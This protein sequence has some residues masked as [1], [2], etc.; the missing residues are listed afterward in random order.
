M[1]TNVHSYNIHC[2]GCDI[3]FVPTAYRV[4][5]G[6]RS[7]KVVHRGRAIDN[8]MFVAAISPARNEKLGYVCYGHS[9]FID[10][11]G[12]IQAKAGTDEEILFYEIGSF[13]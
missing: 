4:D 3:L 2:I 7:W 10:P 9:M 8:Q 6:P 1:G 5:R 12:T 11:N 13:I